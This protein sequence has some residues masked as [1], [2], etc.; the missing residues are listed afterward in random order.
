MKKF[1]LSVSACLVAL[2]LVTIPGTIIAAPVPGITA[3]QVLIGAFQDQSGPAA[4]VGINMRKGM[5]AYLNW[6]NAQGGVNGRKIKL[7]VEDDGFQASRSIA[8]TKKLVEQDKVFALVGTLGTPGLA[9]TIDYIVEKD[10]P[11]IY[12]G[13]GIS[14]LAYP[15]KKQFFPVQP[16]YISE[17]RIIAQYVVEHLKHKRIAVA[18]EQTDIGSQGLRGVKDQ[19][20]R[21]NMEPVEVVNFG[22][23]DVDFSSQILKLI[24]AK[25]ES[26]IIYSTLKPCAGLLKQ[27]ATM[28]LNAQFLTTY[29][30]A[31]PVQMPALAGEA[32]VGLIA[33]GW[34]PVLGNDADSAKYLEI[35]Q[36][37]FPKEMPSAFAAAGFI[38]AEVFTEG[39]KRAGNNPTREGLIAAMETFNDWDG[40]MA[41]GITYTP[42][43]RS[44]KASMYFMKFMKP[45]FE[46]GSVEVISEWIK[47]KI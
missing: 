23:A 41:K 33:P 21:Y 39:L 30:N 10:V 13:S 20:S 29:V 7:I 2:L 46:Q 42:E 47:L 25:P 11:S 32:C 16:N 24:K 37:S 4:V 14:S 35:Y 17:G 6:I 22:A 31:D 45:K 9:A 15:P 40:I 5:E 18:C 28:G 34:V 27:A 8:A 44:G 38:A 19:L 1:W 12:Q 36:K 26:V 43:F 3:D